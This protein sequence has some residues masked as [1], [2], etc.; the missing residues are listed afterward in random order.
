MLAGVPWGDALPSAK[1]AIPALPTAYAPDPFAVAT[2][3]LDFPNPRSKKPLVIAVMIGVAAVIGIGIAIASSSSPP[4]SIAAPPPVPKVEP[5]TEAKA[6]EPVRDEPARDEPSGTGAP[7]TQ[8]QAPSGN[9][10]DLFSKGLK[11]SGSAPGTKGFDEAAARA[12][13]VDLLKTAAACKEPGGPT[14][15]ASTTITFEP[16]GSVSGVTVGAPF[17]GSSTATCIVTTFK[18][19]KIAPFSGLPGTVSQVISL[20]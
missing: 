17:A 18:R 2:T 20:R 16:S 6:T 11:G 5:T 7:A 19:A 9:F 10:S 13:L 1:P 3:D 8:P 15:Q 4:A 14:G 12:A